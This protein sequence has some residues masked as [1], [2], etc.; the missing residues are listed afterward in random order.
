VAGPGIVVTNAHVVAGS[1]RSFLSGG[2][3]YTGAAATVTAFDPINDLAVLVLDPGQNA[4]LPPVLRIV[5][6]VQHGE[7]GAVIGYPLGGRQTAE[8]ARIDRV[9]QFDVEPLTGGTAVA[10]NILAFRAKVQPGNSGGPVVAEDGSVLGLV[11]AQA[12]GQRTE[13]AYGVASSDLLRVIAQGSNRV[14]ASTGR[15]L[16]EEELTTE[17]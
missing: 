12:L 5:Q 10:A 6:R 3:Q 8:S 4:Q 11:V 1:R 14:P 13:A 16:E 17:R 2:P 15:C 9:A 7:P